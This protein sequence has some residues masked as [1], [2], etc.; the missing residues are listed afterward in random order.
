MTQTALRYP[1]DAARPTIAYQLILDYALALPNVAETPTIGYPFEITQIT[2]SA[3]RNLIDTHLITMLVATTP[4]LG[5]DTR[6]GHILHSIR[7]DLI[8]GDARNFPYRPT[9]ALTLKPRIRVPAAGYRIRLV[10]DVAV[11]ATGIRALFILTP[12]D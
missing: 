6:N 9:C 5:G 4:W 7:G 10:R 8:T 1:I 11:A 3:Q 2:L 12:L